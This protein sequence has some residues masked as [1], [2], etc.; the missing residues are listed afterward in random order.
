MTAMLTGVISLNGA[1]DPATHEN[2]CVSVS[3]GF[4]LLKT[5]IRPINAIFTVNHDG[6]EVSL[7]RLFGRWLLIEPDKFLK[8]LLSLQRGEIGIIFSVNPT[9]L[10]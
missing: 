5:F 6:E 1:E 8:F 9:V 7:L 10:I 4:D 2:M 3:I